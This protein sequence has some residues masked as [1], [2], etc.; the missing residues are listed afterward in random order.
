MKLLALTVG[1]KP[2][3]CL[4]RPPA[5]PLQAASPS[6]SSILDV[7]GNFSGVEY[8]PPI[9]LNHHKH[10]HLLPY[11]NAVTVLVLS[12]FSFSLTTSC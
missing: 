5:S 7:Y 11:L 8:L 12:H 10:L 9:L 2:L 4:V 6:V 1:F 3:V